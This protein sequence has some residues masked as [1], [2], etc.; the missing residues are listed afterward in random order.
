MELLKKYEDFKHKKVGLLNDTFEFKNK[1]IP[2]LQ[3]VDDLKEEYTFEDIRRNK[4]KMLDQQLFN[5]EKLLKEK[6][7][8][9]P[10]LQPWRA[11]AS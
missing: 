6:T 1:E 11:W 10:I 4:E 3:S 9:L 5:I 8:Y 2:V 7:D